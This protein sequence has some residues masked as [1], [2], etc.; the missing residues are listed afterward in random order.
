MLA[1]EHNRARKGEKDKSLVDCICGWVMQP[2]RRGLDQRSWGRPYWTKGDYGEAWVRKWVY[3][4][5]MFSNLNSDNKERLR[6][7]TRFISKK[8]SA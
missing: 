6:T 5:G 8:K 1:P 2:R 4:T 7:E 3:A